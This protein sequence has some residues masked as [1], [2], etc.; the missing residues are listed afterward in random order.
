MLISLLVACTGPGGDAATYT[1]ALTPL[2]PANQSP[3]DGVD[4][5]D[6][7]LE[8][9]IGNPE[10]FALD[11]VSGTSELTGLP[12]L[13][14][15]VV[16]VAA[17]QGDT[18]VAS[19]R[20]MPLTTLNEDL[21]SS[22]LI[23]RTDTFGWFPDAATGSALGALA[24][25]GVGGFVLFGG[26]DKS[27]YSGSAGSTDGIWHV[28]V[29]APTTLEFEASAATM[30]EWEPGL[31]GRGGHTAT[32][33]QDGRIWVAG[34]NNEELDLRD[35]TYTSFFYDP[36]AQ[37]V[38]TGPE[39][40][41]TRT[42][43]RAE[44]FSTGDV[45]LIGGWNSV[46]SANQLAPQ[47]SWEIHRMGSSSSEFG[48]LPHDGLYVG[49]ASMGADGVLICGGAILGGGTYDATDACMK[50]TVSGELVDVAP[51]PAPRAHV[52]LAPIGNGQVLAVG[53]TEPS[54]ADFNTEAEPAEGEAWVYDPGTDR[55]TQ[56]GDLNIARAGHELVPIGD[57]QVLVVGGVAEAGL[58]LMHQM[59]AEDPLACPEIYDHATQSFTTVED[60]DAGDEATGL[61]TGVYWPA[62]A[63]DPTYGALVVG[64]VG[65]D[66]SAES[67]V[68]H[69][70]AAQ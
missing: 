68:A 15:T 16:A 60:C 37:T 67:G 70:P 36:A 41:G 62:V 63:S 48:T 66:G 38:T 53:G 43:H 3:F 44:T 49:T 22:V 26:F 46:A 12:A 51:L 5:I 65:K 23:S 69:W 45:A 35:A 7:T 25:D 28:Q 55:W 34:G 61:P 13:E 30:P 6:L 52:E 29:G 33:L 54:D 24:P 9:A 2:V 47:P 56:V 11:G 58:W 57:G 39:L 17:W 50:L 21:E 1:L 32:L 18:V 59:T 64:G 27:W 19:G 8:H 4:R 31:S 40:V 10:T 42:H 14:D 20:T